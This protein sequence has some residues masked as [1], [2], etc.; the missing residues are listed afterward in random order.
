M[1]RLFL[2]ILYA[3]SAFSPSSAHADDDTYVAYLN[4]VEADYI[5]DGDTPT[6]EIRMFGID[7]PEKSQMCERANGSCYKCGQG[8]TR[9]LIRLLD[10][11]ATY[12]FTGESNRGRPI[13]TIF[14]N[15][16]DI[17]L[18]MIRRG[19]GV[20]YERYLPNE[21]R[22]RY[23]DAQDDAKSDRRGIWQGR[24]I[25]PEDW[26]RGERLNCERQDYYD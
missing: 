25:K 19:Q 6:V 20:V 5:K 13:A 15:G 1:T 26:R 7:T 4:G 18:E 17:N 10:G 23:L 16:R 3:F 8:A 14:V 21:M 22:T 2:L 9:E 11:E 24:F 12:R